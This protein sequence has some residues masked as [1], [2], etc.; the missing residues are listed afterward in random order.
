MSSNRFNPD[1]LNKLNNP[2]RLKL[3]PPEYIIEKTGISF[4][5]IIIDYGAGTGLYSAAFATMFKACKVYA[6]DIS[7]IMVCWIKENRTAVYPNIIPMLVDDSK[8]DLDD[9]ICDFL[10]MINLH[11]ELDYPLNTLK[12]CYRL[13]KK[14]G[15]IAISDWKKEKTEMGP[16]ISVRI[17]TNDI[18]RQLCE[19]GFNDI[20]VYEEDLRFN[21]LVVA[22]K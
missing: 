20:S 16:N 4:P 12:E 13:L 10:L 19:T 5:D 14:G 6:V 9:E 3:L 22:E 2:F 15:K 1:Q 8:I 11:H 21:Y 7:E 18:K 17:S